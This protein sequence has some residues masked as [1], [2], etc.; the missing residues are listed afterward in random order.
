MPTLTVFRGVVLVLAASLL[1]HELSASPVV[2]QSQSVA[3]EV[4]AADSELTGNSDTELLA[5]LQWLHEQGQYEDAVSE[6]RA[7]LET[8]EG[9][10]RGSGIQAAAVTDSLIGSL[11]A[12]KAADSSEVLELAQRAVAMRESG[13]DGDPAL[14]AGSVFNL[15][16]VYAAGNQVTTGLDLATRGLATLE[17]AAGYSRSAAADGRRVIGELHLMNG[18]F[19]GARAWLE[20]AVAI[21]GNMDLPD[22]L[23]LAETLLPLG[24]SLRAVGALDEAESAIKRAVDLYTSRYGPGH[25]HVG[26]S[27]TFLGQTQRDSGQ[28]QNARGSLERAVTILAQA[29]GEDSLQLG[30]PLNALGLTLLDLGEYLASAAAFDHAIAIQR[31]TGDADRNLYLATLLSNYGILCARLGNNADALAM[32]EESSRIAESV[33]GPDHP[34]VAYSTANRGVLLTE[35]GRYE[36]AYPLIAKGLNIRAQAYGPESLEV[37]HSLLHFAVYYQAVGDIASSEE[38]ALRALRIKEELL[39][40]TH[41]ELAKIEEL[42]SQLA[43]DRGDFTA[44]LQLARKVLSI[45]QAALGPDVKEV[46]NDRIWIAYLLAR[47]QDFAAGLHEALRG[48]DIGR[49]NATLMFR[50]LAEQQALEYA[51]TRAD[52]IDLLTTIATEFPACCDVGVKAIFD[53]VIRARALVSD[54]MIRR[55]SLAWLAGDEDSRQLT[56]AFAETA[57]KLAQLTLTGGEESAAPEHLA[58]LA[59]AQADH[60]RAELALAAYSER[61]RSEKIYEQAGYDEVVAALPAHSALVAFI[62]YTPQNLSSNPHSRAIDEANEHYAVFIRKAGDDEPIALS[63][64]E[65]RTI[66][67][68]VEAV[69]NLVESEIF[70]AGRSSQRS[71]E[72]FRYTAEP[73]RKLVWDPVAA[74]LGSEIRTVFVVPDGSLNFVNFVALPATGSGYLV[75]S[76]PVFHYLSSERDIVLA[77]PP[78]A[79]ATLLAIGAPDFDEQDLFATLATNRSVRTGGPDTPLLGYR[80][81]RSACESFVLAQ[82]DPLP[83]ASREVAELASIWQQLA[84]DADGSTILLTGAS[85]SERAFKQA[86]AGKRVLHFATHGFFFDRNC[87]A[88]SYP[89]TAALAKTANPL[90]LAGL[91]LA[92]ANHRDAAGPD[93][94]DG[95]LTA[96]EIGTL[97]LRATEW[98][99]LSA[100]DTGIGETRDGE[101]VFGLRRAFRMAGAKTTVMS[102]WAVEDESAREWMTALYRHHFTKGAST[103]DS[104]RQASVDVLQR[105]R[106][107]GLSTHPYYWAGFVAAGDWR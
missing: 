40:G 88:E 10:Y 22:P 87:V 49:Q 97:D 63:L 29:Y 41:I 5:R 53:R 57:R 39:P 2:Q 73:L 36:E 55:R 64:A 37:A 52:G 43:N 26:R 21:L 44:A 25:P 12:L 59:A 14:L 20:D 7:A 47:Q 30:S 69:R 96:E 92:G 77:S 76:E 4:V 71:E 93:E 18:D 48:E 82:F 67:T 16:R 66:D 58:D 105:R 102:L 17:S 54:E 27:L 31:Q 19:D 32:F 99:V 84:G 65:A 50:G 1:A 13:I 91:A 79:S 35:M 89:G 78:P 62:R 11:L 106:T 107:E 51:D 86:A 101:G 104:V 38:Y 34:S 33:L 24:F 75:E 81:S 74:H 45:H 15:A 61:F 28:L 56:A 72:T 90:L 9:E 94:E 3:A 46:A 100:C 42:R 103:L 6:S 70:A 98:S 85:A 23:R 68:A 8:L 80:G 95:I 83:A 60:R